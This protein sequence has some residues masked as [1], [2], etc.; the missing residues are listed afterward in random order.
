MCLPTCV[1]L[2]VCVRAWENGVQNDGVVSRGCGCVDFFVSACVSVRACA[3]CVCACVGVCKR[4]KNKEIN[5][6]KTLCMMV[7][8]CGS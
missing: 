6:E 7:I 8:N 1:F 2:F 3:L 5:N 4:A